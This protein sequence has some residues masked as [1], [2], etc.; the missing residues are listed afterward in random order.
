MV[1]HCQHCCWEG[2]IKSIMDHSICYPRKAAKNDMAGKLWLC[3]GLG[4]KACI[5]RRGPVVHSSSCWSGH[6]WLRIPELTQCC[7]KHSPRKPDI[8]QQ[9]PNRR[10][11]R[12]HRPSRL[13]H[14][15]PHR[16]TTSR[17]TSTTWQPLHAF[18]DRPL[19]LLHEISLEWYRDW[20]K[21]SNWTGSGSTNQQSLCTY[22]TSKLWFE[23]MPVEKSWVWWC[24]W[25]NKVG[26]QGREHRWVCS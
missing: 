11:H 16:P 9:W 22:W 1:R 21:H 2:Q 26:N 3:A 13:T 4:R 17:P 24:L 5:G 7:Q 10:H 23:I 15:D 8:S 19:L 25:W 12:R 14:L 18:S 20:D 6:V